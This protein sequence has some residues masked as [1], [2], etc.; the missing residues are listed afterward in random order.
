MN[1]KKIHPKIFVSHSSKDKEI[2][3][4]LKEY[5]VAM[6]IP[7]E[8]I[9]IS[10]LPEN[11]VKE[12]IPAEVKENIK[13]SL[14]NI[15]ILSASYYQSAY[16]LNEAGIIWLRDGEAK[17]IVI[18]LPEINFS[19]MVGFINSN[20][21]L[22]K[23][24]STDDVSTIYDDISSTLDIAPVSMRVANAECR[25]LISKYEDFLSKRVIEYNKV[26]PESGDSCNL[27]EFTTDDERILLY[28]ITQTKIRK[29]NQE[30]FKDWLNENEIYEVNIANS[31]DL[32]SG[33][34][35]G[36]R[37]YNS[38]LNLEV[39]FFRNITSENKINS[40]IAALRPIVDKHQKLSSISFKEAWENN[41]LADED[42]LFVAYLVD[43]R[44]SRI[45]AGW[46]I[47]HLQSDIDQWCRNE[48]ICLRLKNTCAKTINIFVERNWVFASAF[49]SY[50]NPKEYTLHKSLKELLFSN[51]FEFLE[52]IKTLIDNY[53]LPF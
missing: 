24:D 10:S 28:Y 3:K 27:D 49:T 6:K 26:L 5:L 25:T 34:H 29:I 35:Y 18:G 53:A 11:G 17:T 43:R 9:F 14:V 38:E 50:D 40:Y 36:T 47:T 31:F 7:N 16:C 23:L 1:D 45:L 22:R 2:G 12:N 4:M 19:D 21:I 8:D 13:N 41:D 30:K 48:D 32:F 20:Y 52:E 46:Q 33:A 39:E 42:K 37:Y 44:K 15:I 51:E